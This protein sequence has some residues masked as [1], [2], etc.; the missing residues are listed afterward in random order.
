MTTVKNE[1]FIGL[2]HENSYLVGKNLQQGGMEIWWRRESS[3][4]FF[5]PLVRKT[6]RGGKIKTYYMRDN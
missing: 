4:G 2:E 5:H 6:L 1:V 3:G